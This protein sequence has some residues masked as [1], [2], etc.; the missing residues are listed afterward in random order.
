M[1]N[2]LILRLKSFGYNL[3]SAVVVALLGFFSSP[4][5]ATLITQNFGDTVLSTVLL[6]LVPELVKYIRNAFVIAKANKLAGSHS[7]IA[8]KVTLL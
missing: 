5:F 3:L 8:P 7:S 4:E 2:P 6:L 1:Q